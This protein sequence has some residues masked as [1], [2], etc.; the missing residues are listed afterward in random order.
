LRNNKPAQ[1]LGRDAFLEES[2]G[3][4]SAIEAAPP[5]RTSYAA[6]APA[7]TGQRERF[8]MDEGLSTA[9]DRGIRAA[10]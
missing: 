6:W 4:E 2:V 5:S 1:S 10:A 8:T 9:V 7:S 3:M